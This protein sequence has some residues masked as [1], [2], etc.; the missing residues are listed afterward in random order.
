MGAFKKWAEAIKKYYF[1]DYAL[2]DIETIMPRSTTA[3]KIA[4]CLNRGFILETGL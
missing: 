3:D 4:N 2:T 1:P